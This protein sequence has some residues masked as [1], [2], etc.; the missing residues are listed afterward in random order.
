MKRILFLDD[1]P[2]RHALIAEAMPE[3]VHVETSGD[4]IDQLRTHRWDL[5]LLDHD[6]DQFG[7]V[8]PGTG[9]DVVDWIVDHAAR[10]RDEDTEFIVHSHNWIFGPV[11]YRK[12]REARLRAIRYRAA[13]TDR[14]FL[15]KARVGDWQDIVE[16]VTDPD[17]L[18]IPTRSATQ[19]RG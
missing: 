4:A 15:N 9:E 12:L 14:A 7:A 16:A 6:L 18:K 1:D 5:V 2:V 3:A 17:N 8:D 10:F 19:S 11:M 13:E